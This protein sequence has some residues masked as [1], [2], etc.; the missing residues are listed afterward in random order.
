ML[1]VST[2]EIVKKPTLISQP[3]EITLIEDARKHEPR[4]VLLPYVLYERI[5]EK[6]E[7][8]VYLF[9]NAKA[10]SVGYDEPDDVVSELGK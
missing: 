2:S 6:I 3:N 7:D 9:N 5:K 4:S 8:D 1:V 10:L